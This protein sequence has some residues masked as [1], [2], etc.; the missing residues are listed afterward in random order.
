MAV[1]WSW[2]FGLS[3]CP[4][5]CQTCF[6]IWYGRIPAVSSFAEAATRLKGTYLRAREIRWAN[7]FSQAYILITWM[8]T[9]I[10]FINLTRSSVLLAVRRRYVDSIF[11]KYADKDN[12]VWLTTKCKYHQYQLCLHSTSAWILFP[13]LKAVFVLQEPVFQPCKFAGFSFWLLCRIMVSL[14]NMH[15]TKTEVKRQTLVVQTCF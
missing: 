5:L 11:P 3:L 15:I 7:S 14:Y 9:I 12:K 1:S 13:E 8:P 6:S 2:Y 4:W 10:S